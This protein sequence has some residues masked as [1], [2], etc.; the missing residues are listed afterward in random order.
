M[1]LQ[2]NYRKWAKQDSYKDLVA[3][4]DLFEED[5]RRQADEAKPHLAGYSLQQAKAVA[6]IKTYILLMSQDDT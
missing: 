6:S 3:K 2:A 1:E 5:Y 4:L